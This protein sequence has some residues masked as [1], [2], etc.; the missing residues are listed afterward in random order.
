MKNFGT[1]ESIGMDDGLRALGGVLY[2]NTGLINV[3]LGPLLNMNSFFPP[4][5]SVALDRSRPGLGDG[6]GF[7]FS[8]KPSIRVRLGMFFGGFYNWSKCMMCTL[9]SC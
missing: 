2:T 5:G 4:V 8:C 9:G 6:V 7:G 3:D 1:E